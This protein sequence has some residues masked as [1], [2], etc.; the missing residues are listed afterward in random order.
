MLVVVHGAT[1]NEANIM[2]WAQ[3]GDTRVTECPSDGKTSVNFYSAFTWNGDI[4]DPERSDTGPYVIHF[5]VGELNLPNSETSVPPT[6]LEGLLDYFSPISG[7]ELEND[8]AVPEYQA[9]VNDE[10]ELVTM[11]VARTTLKPISRTD[12]DKLDII[13]YTDYDKLGVIN[14]FSFEVKSFTFNSQSG[15]NNTFL[16]K[17]ERFDSSTQLWE[18]IESMAYQ[19]VAPFSSAANGKVYVFGGYDGTSYI[20]EY[21]SY[22]PATGWET[23]GKMTVGY[24]FGMTATYGGMIYLIGGMDFSGV[25]RIVTQFNPVANTFT[26]FTN[27]MPQGVAMGTAVVSGSYLYVLFGASS[28]AIESN[29]D[30]VSAFN[31]GIFKYDLSSGTTGSWTIEKVSVTPETRTLS[32]AM[33]VGATS[34]ETSASPTAPNGIA[35]INDGGATEELVCFSG[36]K[37]AGPFQLSKATIYAHAIGE[38]FKIINLPENRLNPNSLDVSGTVIR[39]FDGMLF[40]GYNSSAAFIYKGVTADYD[41]VAKTYTG[42][43]SKPNVSR[44][45]AQLELSS[46]KWYLIG[47]SAEKSQWLDDTETYDPTGDAFTELGRTANMLYPRYGFGTASLGGYIYALGGVGSGH[48]PGWLKITVNANPQSVRADGVQ[49]ASITIEATDV[50][51][52]PPPDGTTFLA[53][54]LIS[55]PMTGSQRTEYQSQ[56]DALKQA[57]GEAAATAAVTTTTASK[58]PT[59]PQWISILPVLFSSKNF[60]MTDGIAGTT[61]LARSEDPIKEVDALFNFL[62]GGEVAQDQQEF[63]QLATTQLEQI[64]KSKVGDK[65]DLY[66]ASIEVSCVDG[67]Y[68]GTT[69]TDLALYAASASQ[70][71]TQDGLPSSKAIGAQQAVANSEKGLGADRF[72]IVGDP[73]VQGLSAN[74]SFF[75]DISSIPNVQ[76]ITTEPV[77]PTQA[78][79]DLTS[80]LDEIPFGA[81]PHYDALVKAAGVRAADSQASSVRNMIL[82]VSD[83]QDSLSANS[84]GDVVSAANAVSGDGQCPVFVTN[85]VVTDPVS[86]SARRA[87]TD[88][89]DLE[90]ISEGTGGNS[91]SVVDPSY[92]DFV[93]GRIKTA[94]P[95][96]LSSCTLIGD[97]ELQGPLNSISFSLVGSL[98]GSE[99]S[100]ALFSSD[101]GYNFDPVS[102]D[103]RSREAAS[104]TYTF[105]TP[106]V[107]KY[108]RFSFSMSTTTFMSPRLVTIAFTFVEPNIQY[109]FTYP[110]LVSGQ[111]A[112]LAAIVNHRLPE[113]STVE[114]GLCHGE[115]FYFDRDY[116][117]EVQPAIKE[118]GVILAINRSYDTYLGSDSTMDRLQTDDFQLYRSISG[119]WKQESVNVLVN[120]VSALPSTY[121]IYPEE[122]VV[123]FNS[124]L[125][126]QDVVAITDIKQ[127]SQFRVGLK[128]TNPTLAAGRLDEFAY[129]WT[130]TEDAIGG[131]SNRAPRAINLFVS[132]VPA[133]PGGPLVANYTFVDPDGDIEDQTLTEITWYRNGMPIPDVKNKKTI[134]NS[135]FLAKVAD[136]DP[137]IIKGQEW[138][139]TVRPSDGRSFGP[140]ATSPKVIISNNPPAVDKAKLVS[141]NKDPLVFTTLDVVKVEVKVSDADA[142][143]S[144]KTGIYTW[145]VNDV[146]VKSGA[147]AQIGPEEKDASGNRFLAPNA[148]VKCEVVPY[149]GT[150]YGDPFFT[151][152][153]T[154]QASPPQVSQVAVTPSSPT[155]LSNLRVSYKYNDPDELPDKSLVRWYKDGTRVS[156]LDDL[157]QISRVLLAPGQKWQAGVIPSN[158]LS[159]GDEVKSNTVEVTF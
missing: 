125:D 97:Y 119:G 42:K 24:G 154:V 109:L 90:L 139:F 94:A 20:Q 67:F 148:V 14:R 76:R 122:G 57:S 100:M 77:T 55:F 10:N 145:Y 21:E 158:G 117:S 138:F 112:E 40:Y 69:N 91:F 27:T 101:D 118:R 18:Q 3:I 108:I 29:G 85:F 78:K 99:A 147:V 5:L 114:I 104:A 61:V 54:G 65:R 106:L 88:V 151:D 25:S 130:G 9:V 141:S 149:D 38:T 92:I 81:S 146:P 37:G 39:V 47:G 140:L 26:T 86:L 16:D 87:R 31:Y 59:A 12:L 124:K 120:N 72:S 136:K 1:W 159:E 53:K 144:V 28:A 89:A 15:D 150:D 75:S 60:S 131:R 113:G 13:A 35:I 79:A 83:N 137:G 155:L 64:R 143:D 56:I 46:G 153:I 82:S 107:K 132:P 121:R 156:E 142:S 123:V 34:V 98:V 70:E 32:A 71:T 48:A 43:T 58:A 66:T 111:V 17:A 126:P 152:S 36:N 103:L 93:I 84:A 74:V 33:L 8:S 51:G 134:R 6:S 4:L 96:S 49:T 41:P 23:L 157:S 7:V 2:L 11:P 105:P 102:I 127:P 135:D 19:R 52:D 30:T 95:S 68:Y 133:M 116:A 63:K 62:V 22:A 80:L 115:S 50:S 44:A 129:S 110:Q 45:K 128:I 73:A